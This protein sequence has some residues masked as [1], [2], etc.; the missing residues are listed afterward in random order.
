M[1]KSVSREV[2]WIRNVSL[3]LGPAFTVLVLDISVGVGGTSMFLIAFPFSFAIFFCG[4]DAGERARRE[5][6][7][8]L[9]FTLFSMGTF[10]GA[11]YFTGIVPASAFEIGI[12]LGAG[13]VYA[14]GFYT[15]HTGKSL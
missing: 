10:L 2:R 3:F 8:T 11:G 9:P 4:S 13:A 7:Q 6:P 14:C 1:G 5:Q 15:G 12:I